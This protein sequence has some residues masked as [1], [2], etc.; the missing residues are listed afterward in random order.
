MFVAERRLSSRTLNTTPPAGLDSNASPSSPTIAAPDDME[1]EKQLQAEDMG[2]QTAP[3][4]RSVRAL[5]PHQRRVYLFT[6]AFVVGE[7]VAGI[8]VGRRA[9]AP[10]W[11]PD[12]AG[13]DRF[14]HSLPGPVMMYLLELVEQGM[15]QVYVFVQK[16]TLITRVNPVPTT[17][18]FATT[19]LSAS[20]PIAEYKRHVLL[21]AAAQPLTALLSYAV[22]ALSRIVPTHELGPVI[23]STR[24]FTVSPAAFLLLF[25]FP[26]IDVSERLV[27]LRRPNS[28]SL[29]CKL[30][31]NG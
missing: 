18:G 3:A 16:V 14:M 13:G 27:R 19:L 15:V 5:A 7:I 23:M 22:T 21:Y 11:K 2:A 10:P 28:E 6:F 29:D 31:N 4:S 1:L 20:L 30:P 26:F 12:N 8:T 17:L 9:M 25:E 24:F